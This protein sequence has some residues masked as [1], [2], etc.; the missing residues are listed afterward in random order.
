RN[1]TLNARANRSLAQRQRR[2]RPGL[3]VLEDRAVPAVLNV[4]TTL[5]VLEPN[6]GLL[7]LREAVIQANALPGANTIVVPAGTYALALAGYEEDASLTGDLDLAGHVTVQGAGAGVT[8]IDGAGLDRIFHIHAG[9]DVTLTGMTIRGGHVY[10]GT[11]LT[12]YAGAL[13]FSDST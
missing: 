12:D 1:R 3:E 13:T 8:T 4:T 5:D 11:I 6:D 2:F 7:S 10:Y 9:A